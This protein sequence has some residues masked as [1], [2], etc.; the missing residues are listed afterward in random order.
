MR[1]PQNIT[2]SSTS[3]SSTLAI[4][5]HHTGLNQQ[6]QAEGHDI[7]VGDQM[8]RMVGLVMSRFLETCIWVLAAPMKSSH[9][10][11]YYVISCNIPCLYHICD[12]FPLIHLHTFPH[13][14]PCVASLTASAPFSSN[15]MVTRWRAIAYKK[16]K[17]RE[18]NQWYIDLMVV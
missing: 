1:D 18:Q 7:T 3:S 9:K 8:D 17:F 5:W 11:P 14:M 6:G 16:L 15:D 2:C 13:M 4:S 12:T 10:S